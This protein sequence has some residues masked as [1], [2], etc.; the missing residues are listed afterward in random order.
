MDILRSWREQKIMLKRR[1]SILIDSD[2]DYDSKDKENMF[3]KLGD[4]LN[5]SRSEIDLLF[6]EL[7]R[8]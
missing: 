6:A 3:K 7:Q 5:M 8:Y 2:F 4:K 1:F